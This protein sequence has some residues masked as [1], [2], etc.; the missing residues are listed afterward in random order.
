M[1]IEQWKGDKCK[2]VS[3]KREDVLELRATIVGVYP[4]VQQTVHVC[5]KCGEKL[6]VHKPKD[7]TKDKTM[8]EKLLDIIYELVDDA[9]DS[10]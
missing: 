2:K 1:K 4:T 7:S 6:G 9:L 5:I 10:R 8:A 3:E